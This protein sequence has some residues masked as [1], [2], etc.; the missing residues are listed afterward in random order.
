MT[1]EESNLSLRLVAIGKRIEE[2]CKAVQ[3][4]SKV[5]HTAQEAQQ[6]T[7]KARNPTPV[8]VTYDDQTV[9]NTK[10]ENDRQYITQNSIKNWT[11]V[12]VI[13]ATIYAAIAALQWCEMRKATNAA[14]TAANV[15][16][17]QLDVSERPWARIGISLSGPLVI[18]RNGLKMTTKIVMQNSGNSPATTILMESRMRV[19]S[20]WPDIQITNERN[21]LCEDLKQR[22]II[23]ENYLETLFPGTDQSP[24]FS[25]L[26]VS[27]ADLDQAIRIGNGRIIPL[28]LTCVVYRS[29]FN[30]IF[31]KT[32]YSSVVGTFN[33]SIPNPIGMSI[34]ATQ[35]QTISPD[36]LYM[37]TETHAD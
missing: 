16:A 17:K 37:E 33:P 21:L 24:Q 11:K 10:D 14:T 12:A 19:S 8:I 29:I 23:N 18:D 31:H 9:R 6:Q 15:A 1:P 25:N 20:G 5:I 26:S 13:A 4:N 3:Q 35:D 27:R 28:I 36:H 34:L 2:L 32:A 30:D 7:E 22:A